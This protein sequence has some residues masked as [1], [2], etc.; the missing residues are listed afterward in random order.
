M[1]TRTMN[2]KRKEFAARCPCGNDPLP[3]GGAP[4]CEDCREAQLRRN[5]RLGRDVVAMDREACAASVSYR[6]LRQ[7]LKPSE[8]RDWMGAERPS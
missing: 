5:G 2:T 6:D 8:M 7:P 1:T 4:V 3:G